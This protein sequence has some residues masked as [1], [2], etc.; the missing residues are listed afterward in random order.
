MK[1]VPKVPK[2]T[3]DIS[4]G[5]KDWPTFL[6]HALS[7]VITIVAVYLVLGWTCDIVSLYIPDRYEARLFEWLKTGR[8]SKDTPESARARGMFDEMAARPELR[9]LPYQLFIMKSRKPNAFA[10]PGGGVGLTR[11]L[12]KEVKSDAGLALVIGHELGHHQHRDA[13][14]GLGRS[15]LYQVAMSIFFGDSKSS[16][17]AESM[18]KAAQAGYSR[19]RERRADEFGL[20]LVHDVFGHREGEFEFFEKLVKEG[21]D[22]SSKWNPFFQSHPYTPER[23][24]YLKGLDKELQRKDRRKE[25]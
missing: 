20:K 11:G 18:L 15:L 1:F 22:K 17:A 16:S 7:A 4:T 8:Q 25:G 21:K 19:K 14:R 23:I 9:K 24:K 5:T 12:V 13:M 10:F 2:K 3:A 6:K